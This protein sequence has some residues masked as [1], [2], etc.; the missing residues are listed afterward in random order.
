MLNAGES[1]TLSPDFT[2][3]LELAEGFYRDAAAPI[4]RACFPQLAY[5]AALIGWGSEVLGYDDAISADHHWG[6]RFLLFLSAEDYGAHAQAL[7]AALADHLPHRFRDY[8]T[9][10]SQPDQVGVRLPE[11]VE[12][13]PVHHMIHIASLP[14]FFKWYLDWDLREPLRPVDWLTFSEQ[15]LLMLTRGKVFYDGLGQLEPLREQLRYFPHDVWLYLLAA[16]WRRIAQEQAFMGRC[17][18]VDDD[19]GSRLVA[20][21]LVRDL[22]RLG[23]LMERRYTPYW[24]WFGTAFRELACARTLL[25][26][27]T[28]VLQAPTW[29]E[30]E[31]HLS[32]AYAQIAQMHNNLCVTPPLATAVSPYYTRPFLVIHAEQFVEALVASITDSQVRDLPEG[33]GSVD[34]FLDSTDALNHP[35]RFKPLYMPRGET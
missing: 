13:G 19:L 35:E 16:Q 18:Q 24:K 10:F 27:F 28:R 8:S 21:R 3:G 30:R 34:Q 4:L 9:S 14:H 32:A 12:T 23:F 22:M 17:G 29:Q 2:P 26:L 20:A 15:R 31:T 11:E 5:S 33:L 25:P 7:S 6:P 1:T